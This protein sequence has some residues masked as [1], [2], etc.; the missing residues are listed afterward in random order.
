M[1]A[2]VLHGRAGEVST[3]CVGIHHGYCFWSSLRLD[4]VWTGGAHAL[5]MIALA[6]EKESSLG[7]DS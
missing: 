1:A 3:T 4:V 5:F 6:R 7:T 2:S